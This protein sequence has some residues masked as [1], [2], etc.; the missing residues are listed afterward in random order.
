MPSNDDWTK[1]Y[2]RNLTNKELADILEFSSFYHEAEIACA[3][4]RE[5]AKR[6]R[7]QPE[8]HYVVPPSP[9]LPSLMAYAVLQDEM[10]R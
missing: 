3:A 5:A 9:H 4:M 8:P 7:E 2:A 6:L 1:G 10:S